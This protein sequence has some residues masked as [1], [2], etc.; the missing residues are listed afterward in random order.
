[1]NVGNI[2]SSATASLLGLRAKVRSPQNLIIPASNAASS[3]QSTTPATDDTNTTTA[4][5]PLSLE[6][7]QKSWGT[8]DPTYDLN[9]DGNVDINDISQWIA[10][11][12]HEVS[13]T[14]AGDTDTVGNAD[15]DSA[16]PASPSPVQLT[17]AGFDRTWGSNDSNYD[18]NGDGT[19]NIDDLTTWVLDPNAIAQH[20]SSS[21]LE[22]GSLDQPAGSVGSPDAVDNTMTEDQDDVTENQAPLS[23]DAQAWQDQWGQ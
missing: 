6:G 21:D 9:A 18:L 2:A 12:M 15:T 10:D 3:A 7:F 14:G 13:G 20:P 1:M 17:R 22:T 23:E 8:N 16:T 11:L 19:V 4:N 5:N